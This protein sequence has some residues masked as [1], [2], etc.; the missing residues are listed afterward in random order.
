MQQIKGLIWLTASNAQVVEPASNF[1]DQ[2][3]DAPASEAQEVL[4]NPAPLHSRD[5]IFHDEARAGKELVHEFIAHTQLFS[6][7]FF[8]TCWIK[9]PSGA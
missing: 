8:F 1:H 9:T 7:G 3:R 5:D 6:L 4:D 2:V